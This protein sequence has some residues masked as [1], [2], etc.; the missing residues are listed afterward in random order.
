MR[1]AIE[2]LGIHYVGGGRTATLNLLEPLFELDTEN[3]YLVL[4]TQPEP[5][6]QTPAGNVRQWIAP[7]RNRVLLRLWAQLV[8]PPALRGYDLTHF[9]KMM[10]VF[11]VPTRTVVTMY[12]VTTLVHPEIFP[13]L[14]VWYWRTLQ[15]RTLVTADMVI[16]ISQNTAREVARFY[17]VR[18]ER[19][20]VIYP[21]L[22][23]QFRPASAADIADFRRRYSLPVDYIA[24]VGHL[25]RKK[26]LSMLVEAFAQIRNQL[27]PGTK[28]VLAGEEYPRMRDPSLYAAIDALNLRDDVIFT[29]RLSDSDVPVLFS[30]AQAAVFPSLHEGFGLSPL[31]ALACGAPLITSAAGAVSEAVGDAAEVVVAPDT[32]SFGAALLRVAGDEGRRRDLRRR[33]LEQAARFTREQTARQ[34]LALYREVVNGR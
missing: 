22:G 11:G 30:G 4:L 29:G 34:T 12:D 3:E 7:L 18:P 20:T 6:L 25:E 32:A 28:L 9:V 15:K 8:L 16:A 31:E 17:P 23:P 21:G 24:F 26:N 10:G 13:W 5:S 19:L 2:A 33:G 14:D 27:C 1:I